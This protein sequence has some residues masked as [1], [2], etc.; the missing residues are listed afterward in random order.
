M[1]CHDLGHATMPCLYSSMCSCSQDLSASVFCTAELCA[2]RMS[3]WTPY[4][5]YDRD[6]HMTL[7]R[8]CAMTHWC[9]M[10]HES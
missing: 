4:Y 2:G 1:S 9:I 7:T 8:V 5:L 6:W 10:S 3:T